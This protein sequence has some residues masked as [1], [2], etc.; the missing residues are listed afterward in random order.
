MRRTTRSQS[1]QALQPPADTTVP[2][3]PQIL[4]KNAPNPPEITILS[5]AFFTPK[6]TGLTRASTILLNNKRTKL[7]A[8]NTQLRSFIRA[9]TNAPNKPLIHTLQATLVFAQE[10]AG[11]AVCI[12][13]Q[14]LLLTCSHCVAD[15]AETAMDATNA[16]WLI[17]ATGEVVRAVCVAWDARRD[18]ALLCITAAE[19]PASQPQSTYLSPPLGP[20]TFPYASISQM[21]RLRIRTPLLC[22]G[23]P[24]SE[25]LE[26]D[27]PGIA[28]G[29]DVLHISEGVYRG[30]AANQDP[31]DNSEIGALMHDC[32]ILVGLHSSWEEESDMRR[33]VPLD[34]LKA[35]LME[36]TTLTFDDSKE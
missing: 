2:S 21:P 29:Y 16:H 24:G 23:H 19:P 31:H 10:E 36:Y 28:T 3:H 9:P 34:A 33:G 27:T 4:L 12:S 8:S 26:A 7:R 14:G 30:L 5:N 18:L 6:L 22:T 1:R 15:D 17:F 35:F 20:R 25:D 13:A 11:T 32:W